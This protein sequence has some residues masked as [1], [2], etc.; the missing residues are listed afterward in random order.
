MLL[1]DSPGA[2]APDHDRRRD[3]YQRP[4]VAWSYLLTETANLT[5]ACGKVEGTQETC[6][7][8]DKS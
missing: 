2:T 3:P 6:N 5:Y 1:A 7:Q 8:S 4:A